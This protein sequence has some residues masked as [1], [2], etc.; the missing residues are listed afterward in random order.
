[1]SVQ[2]KMI[3]NLMRLVLLGI[4]YVLALPCMQNIQGDPFQDHLK[5]LPL[6]LYP[7]LLQYLQLTLG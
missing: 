2:E 4:A 3:H 7:A 5:R 6:L 1:M